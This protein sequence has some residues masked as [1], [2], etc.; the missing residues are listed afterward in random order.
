LH[1]H[2][3]LH[4]QE[5]LS[6]FL[7]SLW[8]VEPP[9]LYAA[10]PVGAVTKT[11][12]LSWKT[13]HMHDTNVLLRTLFPVPPDPNTVE[14]S[15][16]NQLFLCFVSIERLSQILFYILLACGYSLLNERIDVTICQGMYFDR[17]VVLL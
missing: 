13:F 15:G 12:L 6:H 5:C 3:D 1:H 7:N 9:T 4:V 16:L 2:L 11:L 14:R 17:N 8:I 10:A